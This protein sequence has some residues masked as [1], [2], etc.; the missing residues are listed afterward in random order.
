MGL[1][2][3]KKSEEKKEL[4]VLLELEMV[5]HNTTT[6]TADEEG[7]FCAALFQTAEG[8]EPGNWQMLAKSA[9]DG[10]TFTL[11]VKEE[12]SDDGKK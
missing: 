9:R 10:A 1:M 11:I 5:M 6:V 8:L 3:K 7:E 4:P 2:K 12:K